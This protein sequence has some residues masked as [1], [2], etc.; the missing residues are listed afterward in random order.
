MKNFIFALLPLAIFYSCMNNNNNQHTEQEP[1][2]IENI[3]QDISNKSLLQPCYMAVVGKDSA[4]LHIEKD[5]AEVK[6]KLFYKPLE[7]DSRNGSFEGILIN[8]TLKLIYTFQAEGTES[9]QELYLKLDDNKLVEAVGEYEEK[10]GK[11]VYKQPQ[12]FD[13]S[14]KSFVFYPSDCLDK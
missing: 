13:F 9:V 7:K 11:M 10:N 5:N 8:D 6:G 2:T 3:A 1:D 14:G 12:S 4:F